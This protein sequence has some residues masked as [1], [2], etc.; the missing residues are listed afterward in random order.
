MFLGKNVFL[1]VCLSVCGLVDVA[2][3]YRTTIPLNDG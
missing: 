3:D 2:I 1:T